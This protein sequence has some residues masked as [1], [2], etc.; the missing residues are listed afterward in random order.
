MA[1]STYAD[2]RPDNVTYVN[3]YPNVNLP[4]GPFLLSTLT[5]NQSEYI[6]I[7]FPMKVTSL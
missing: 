7:F 4:F 2:P 5:P 3:D 1:S 6:T